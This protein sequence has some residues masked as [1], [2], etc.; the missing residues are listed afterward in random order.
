VFARLALALH[1]NRAGYL[2]ALEHEGS[3]ANPLWHGSGSHWSN[4]DRSKPCRWLLDPPPRPAACAPKPKRHQVPPSL[5]LVPA[6]SFQRPLSFVIHEYHHSTSTNHQSFLRHIIHRRRKH[7]KM[8]AA[9]TLLRRGF[10]ATVSGK[11]GQPP[12]SLPAWGILTLATTSAIFFAIL[13]TVRLQQC[14]LAE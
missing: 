12:T 2:T 5:L 6:P 8:N 10:E 13:F 4:E 3:H 1:Q 9:G 7:S 11:D 14:S